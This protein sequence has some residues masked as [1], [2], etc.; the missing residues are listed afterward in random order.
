MAAATGS[1]AEDIVKGERRGFMLSRCG[2]GGWKRSCAGVPSVVLH[3]KVIG[4]EFMCVTM[5]AQRS[6]IDLCPQFDS[7]TLSSF[8]AIS[9]STFV[10]MD[11]CSFQC[12][13]LRA[14]VCLYLLSLFY[15]LFVFFQNHTHFT[16]P[17]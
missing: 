5:C 9:W 7:D 17:D 1:A 13:G 6:N 15:S 3:F 16:N 12:W 2:G 4:G 14:F 8:H 11:T 10:D